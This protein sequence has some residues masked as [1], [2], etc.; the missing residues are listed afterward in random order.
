MPS[1]RIAVLNRVFPTLSCNA[2]EDSRVKGIGH[3]S[4]GTRREEARRRGEV[5]FTHLVSRS[6]LRHVPHLLE[7][8]PRDLP[9][10]TPLV[11][12]A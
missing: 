4:R 7:E 10:P 8:C 2:N 9:L 12:P 6:L 1:S 5:K 3:R 11:S